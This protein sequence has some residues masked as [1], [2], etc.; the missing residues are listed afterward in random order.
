MVADVLEAQT[1]E[2]NNEY[3]DKDL[4]VYHPDWLRLSKE[5]DEELIK[6]HLFDITNITL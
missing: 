4:F 3:K 6:R 2:F 5:T 1:R